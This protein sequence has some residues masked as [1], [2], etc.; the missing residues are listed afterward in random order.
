[1]T[2]QK[3]WVDH[4]NTFQTRP[5]LDTF[6]AEV[7]FYRY[8]D[9]QNLSGG[10]GAIPEEELILQDKDSTQSNYL[11]WTETDQNTWTYT[12]TN[13]DRY[14]PNAMPWKY[15]VEEGEVSGYRDASSNSETV[16]RMTDVQIRPMA[17]WILSVEI[18][19][20]RL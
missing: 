4:S 7:K 9:A 10:A 6:K 20:C 8:A 18:L 13:L 16:N 11:Q 17:R 14:A 1:M 5:T 12:V 3:I 2:G 19:L 15:V